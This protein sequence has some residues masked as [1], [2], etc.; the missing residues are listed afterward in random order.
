MTSTIFRP[1]ATLLVLVA[2]MVPGCREHNTV[3]EEPDL[4]DIDCVDGDAD[5]WGVGSQC[6]ADDAQDCDDANW[7]TYPGAPEVPYDGVDQ[8][9]DGADL[10]DVD[11]DGYD[12]GP[13]GEDCND[14]N[15]AV[16]PGA[17]EIVCDGLD[18]DCDAGTE[19]ATDA[20][21]DGVTDCD[22]DCDDHDPNTYPGAEEI[23][24]DDVDQDCDGADLDDVD[25]DGFVGGEAG[26]DCDDAND[27]VHPNATED[28][29]NGLD[30]DCDPAT[31]DAPDVDGDGST[32]CEGD[33]DD[34][35]ATS[36][37]GAPE[38]CDGVD[39]DCDPSTEP[40]VDLDGD[41]YAACDGDCLDG[42]A[43][44]FPGLP[45]FWSVPTDFA[46]IQEAIDSVDSGDVICVEAGT[47][48]ETIVFAGRDAQVVGTMGPVATTIEGNGIASVVAITSGEGPGTLLAGLTLTGGG[49]ADG[50]GLRVVGAD[51]TIRD[52]VVSGNFAAE[53][54]GGIYMEDSTS[55][56]TDIV[57]SGNESTYSGGGIYLSDTITALTGVE[58]TG[59]QAIYSGGG[60]Y[61]DYADTWLSDVVISNNVAGYT[62][63]G[64]AFS[65]EMAVAD[66]TDVTLSDNQTGHCGG[67]LV[68]E[69][70]AIGTVRDS[71]VTNNTSWWGA[72]IC[73]ESSSGALIERVTFTG[74]VADPLSGYGGGILVKNALPMELI[75]VVFAENS[76][77]H[78]G[79]ACVYGCSVTFTGAVFSANS[80]NEGGAILT[81]SGAQVSLYDSW[82]TGNDATMRGGGMR[83]LGLSSTTLSRVRIIGNLADLSGGGIDVNQADLLLT[84]S[85][86]AGNQAVEVGGGVSFE[87]MCTSTLDHVAIVGNEAGLEGGGV[88]DSAST[89]PTFT[90]TTITDNVSGTGGGGMFVDGGVISFR[91]SNVFGN[92][93]NDFQGAGS[94]AGVDGN[95]SVGPDYLDTSPADP[96][97]WDLHLDPTSPLIDLAEPTL[98]DPDGGLPDIGPYGGPDAGDFDLDRDGY[99]EWWQPGPYDAVTYPALGWDCDDA[100]PMTYPGAGC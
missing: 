91:Y 1:L 35:D 50:G 36:Y 15:A 93:P 9:C 67:G 21:G 30:D 44:L 3:V 86:V 12:G 39:N 13:Q 19:D 76:S 55:D 79:G 49:G 84:N 77:Q 7:G 45:G 27:D 54:G 60:I 53:S 98:T 11:G 38:L 75:D 90:N 81:R 18:N 85:I 5:G 2:T 47:Y 14:G 69:Y 33:C 51:P 92:T 97:D 89:D 80:A 87:G 40:E 31:P 68:Y 63:G 10:T 8:D 41:G 28:T 22:G 26:E 95:V 83:L 32:T 25:G 78:G 74:N 71:F 65:G 99:P 42:D 70:G 96:A 43:T 24:Y 73:I 57:V 66:L 94:P 58:V 56:L 61:T 17:A 23:A 37:P 6:P 62:G 88:Y 29:C 64:A 48:T 52:L 46:T 20:D 59:N 16:H 100:D 72:G 4:P 34:G 82:I